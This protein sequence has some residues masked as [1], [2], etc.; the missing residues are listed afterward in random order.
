MTEKRHRRTKANL[1]Q[2]LARAIEELVKEVGFNNVTLTGLAKKAKIEPCVIY[3][4]YE[5]LDDL[6]DKYVRRYDY[7]FS[8]TVEFKA[9]G[10]DPREI[11]KSVLTELI[12]ALYGNEIMQEL[13]KWEL[14]SVN[15][16]TV[17]NA[18]SRE[19]HSMPMLRFFNE[20]FSGTGVDF[21]PVASLL[22][23][24]IYY[25]I[26]HKR[27][28]TFC[29]LDYDTAQGKDTLIRSA[30]LAVDRIFREPFPNKNTVDTDSGILADVAKKM[31]EKGI[32]DETIKE[33]TGL[34]LK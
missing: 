3:S 28:S 13:L 16:T 10:K 4:R 31:A 23:G 27:T 9:S 8:D 24:G 25:L 29:D 34:S 21:G 7:W 15:D 18:K 32:D 19:V 5:D 14:S 26:L 12:D 1:E 11:F 17:R 33:I 6:L 30:S 22:I 2:D 20:K